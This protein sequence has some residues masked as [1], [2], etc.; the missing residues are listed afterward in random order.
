MT[1]TDVLRRRVAELASV[2]VH[3]CHP[4]SEAC[5]CFA[6]GDVDAWEQARAELAAEVQA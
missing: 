6:Q 5:H 1:K 3:D 2:L 4:S